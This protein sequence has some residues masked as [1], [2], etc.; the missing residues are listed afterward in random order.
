MRNADALR[1]LGEIPRR[2]EPE[3]NAMEHYHGVEL[4]PRTLDSLVTWDVCGYAQREQDRLNSA[5]RMA[6]RF[7]GGY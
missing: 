5:T 2:L 1:R 4:A 7:K 6:T 3:E